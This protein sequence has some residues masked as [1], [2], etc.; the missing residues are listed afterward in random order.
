MEIQLFE[1]STE[2]T[3]TISRKEI[4]DRIIDELFD[5]NFGLVYSQEDVDVIQFYYKGHPDLEAFLIIV[6]LKFIESQDIIND[7]ASRMK[8]ID[9]KL[10]FM[11]V[12]RFG[13]F[14]SNTS[15]NFWYYLPEEDI[16]RF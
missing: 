7:T 6:R 1:N 10:G 2:L 15:F 14:G 12:S 9:S 11:S 3:I 13:I 8:N 5:S 16:S 4:L